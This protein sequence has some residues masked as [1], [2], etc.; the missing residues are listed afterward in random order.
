MPCHA[1]E[2]QSSRRPGASPPRVVS[3]A[4]AFACVVAAVS[5]ATACGDSGSSSGQLDPNVMV[6]KNYSSTSVTGTQIPGGGPL[7]VSF[8]EAGRI[9]TT[10]GCN[11]HNGAVTFTD[12]T[13]RANKLASTMM[14]CPPPRDGADNWLNDFLSDSVTW[15]LDGATLTLSH[16]ATKVVLAE[17]S[18]QT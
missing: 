16:G 7:E 1:G 13:F 12:D 11:R 17:T 5:I 18:D 14:A 8:P 6:G 2:T 9:S 4:V 3:R 10:A 15:K